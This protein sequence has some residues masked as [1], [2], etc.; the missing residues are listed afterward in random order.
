MRRALAPLLLAA[1][2]TTA[3]PA[4][5]VLGPAELR[6]PL[7][8]SAE[9]LVALLDR[10]ETAA[11]T[12]GDLDRQAAGASAAARSHPQSFAL[13]A[14]AAK[15]LFR[16]ALRRM[17]LWELEVGKADPRIDTLL[18]AGERIPAE[19]RATLLSLAR[20]GAAFG[21]AAA[22]LEPARV[23]GHLTLGLNLT[24]QAIAEGGLN[25]LMQGLPGR[26]RDAVDRAVA[27]DRLHDGAGPLRLEGRFFTNVPWP[28]RDLARAERALLDAER[29]APGAF[30]HLFLGD[31]RWRQGRASE[32]RDAWSRAAEAAAASDLGLFDPLASAEARQRLLA[33]AETK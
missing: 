16:A 3:P 21:E 9:T 2:A 6:E 13:Q 11:R 31:L 29:I 25:A 8:A 33:T 4:D 10:T 18:V 12:L 7:R 17:M 30:V 14:R 19:R 22:R 24:I 15:A 26:I 5:E 27:A 20:E 28:L 23:E 1:C 32:A